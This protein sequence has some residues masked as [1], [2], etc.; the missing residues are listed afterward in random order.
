MIRIC[1]FIFSSLIKLRFKHVT[2]VPGD[3]I[4]VVESWVISCFQ[5]YLFTVLPNS[6]KYQNLKHHWKHFLINALC[7]FKKYILEYKKFP[8]SQ[9]AEK[10]LSHIDSDVRVN[11]LC[12]S[13]TPD[14][15]SVMSLACRRVICDSPV[16]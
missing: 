12:F 3:N 11:W 6:S 14:L 8:Y 4:G 13:A 1:V 9:I 2:N 7:H 15:E 10:T 5:L 16:K